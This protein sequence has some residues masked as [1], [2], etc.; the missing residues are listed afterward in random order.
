MHKFAATNFDAAGL[1]LLVASI[2][3]LITALAGA[4]VT[5]RVRNEVRTYNETTTGG[6]AAQ[7]ETRR[8]EAMPHDERTAKEQRH[9]DEAPPDEPPQGP[10]R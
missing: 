10:S 2:A 7:A 3:T 8:V 1:A 4:I 9:L 6:L 5:V